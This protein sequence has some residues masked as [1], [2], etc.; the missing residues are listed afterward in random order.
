VTILLT[1]ADFALAWSILENTTPLKGKDC[2]QLCQA[3]CC[4]DWKDDIGIYLFPGEECMLSRDDS[5]FLWEKHSSKDYEF[6]PSWQ[7]EYYFL[8]CSGSC[9]RSNR[10]LQCRLFPLAPLLMPSGKL[11]VFMPEE[12]KEVCP[13]IKVGIAGLDAEFISK[14]LAVWRVLLK[15][16]HI[17]DDIMWQNRNLNLEK[18]EMRFF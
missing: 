18:I 1:Q 14:C 7:G 9:K 4:S 12:Y 11:A 2:G 13:L 10:P 6:C 17:Y 8:R 15:D 16:K 3:K 5:T